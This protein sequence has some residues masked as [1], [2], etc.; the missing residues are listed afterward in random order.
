MELQ[1]ELLPGTERFGEVY[2]NH[3]VSATSKRGTFQGLILQKLDRLAV[4]LY[5]VHLQVTRKFEEDYTLPT[6]RDISIHRALNV[7]IRRRLY[8]HLD[9]VILDVKTILGLLFCCRTQ[10]RG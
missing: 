6:L 4:E 1:L 9:F 2:R 8:V 10:G 5:F 3:V 7:E